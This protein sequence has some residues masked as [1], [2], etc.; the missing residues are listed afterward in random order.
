MARWRVAQ[1]KQQ[2]TAEDLAELQRYAREGK[3]GPG[4][5]VQPPGAAD[6]LY[7]SE[8]PELKT[9]FRG[10]DDLDHG[11][12]RRSGGP[13]AILILL[14]LL[15]IGGAAYGVYYYALTIPKASDLDM[16]GDKGLKLEEML[17]TSVGG[18]TLRDKAEDSGAGTVTAPKDSKVKLLA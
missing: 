7:A 13:S 11:P 12:P 3:V 4:D 17:V 1:G 2:F 8:L 9:H 18:A 16:L 15:G 10:A 14:L 6:W 5:M